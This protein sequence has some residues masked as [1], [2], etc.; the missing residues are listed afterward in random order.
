MGKLQVKLGNVLSLFGFGVLLELTWYKVG[1]AYVTI[2]CTATSV[3]VVLVT[4]D[5]FCSDSAKNEWLDRTSRVPRLST[6][7]VDG[8]MSTHRKVTVSKVMDKR[9]RSAWQVFVL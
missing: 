2:Q 6:N 5:I 4:L 8:L 9:H 7:C 3:T 1:S